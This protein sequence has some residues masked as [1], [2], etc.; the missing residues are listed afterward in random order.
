MRQRLGGAWKKK[1]KKY[2]FPARRKGEG[3]ARRCDTKVS[4]EY[5]HLLQYKTK[6]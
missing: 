6:K 4:R 3:G 5:E 2:P 1:R